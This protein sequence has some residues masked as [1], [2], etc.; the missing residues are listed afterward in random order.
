MHPPNFFDEAG[1]VGGGEPKLLTTATRS[2]DARDGTQWRV[3]EA[4]A[5]NVPGAW[6][7]HCLIFDSGMICRRIWRYPADWASLT[8]EALLALMERLTLPASA[9]GS[10]TSAQSI[11]QR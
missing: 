7:P 4:R 1:L 8:E 10:M 3:R 6:G 11:S 2:V 9:A 5:D